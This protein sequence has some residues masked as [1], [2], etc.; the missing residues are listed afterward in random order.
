MSKNTL[1]ENF[2][3]DHQIGRISRGNRSHHRVAYLGPTGTYT[4]DAL[5]T[6][7]D[8]TRSSLSGETIDAVFEALESDQ[9]AYGV[10]PI[11]IRQ[12]RRSTE[13]SISY[14]RKTFKSTPR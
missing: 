11:K 10:V 9:A 13:H 7:F 6:H 8:A 5:L 14:W 12:R 4:E 1:S 2:S 3:A